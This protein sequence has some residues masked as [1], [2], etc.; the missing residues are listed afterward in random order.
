MFWFRT[1]LYMLAELTKIDNMIGLVNGR[2]I[3][4]ERDNLNH[5]N[6]KF[7][8]IENNEFVRNQ[9][10]YNSTTDKTD[11][12]VGLRDENNLNDIK[13]YLEEIKNGENG[14]N[15]ERGWSV[16]KKIETDRS[17]KD[18]KKEKKLFEESN[19]N[20]NLIIDQNHNYKQENKLLIQSILNN[21][22]NASRVEKQNNKVSIYNSK[23]GKL[24]SDQKDIIRNTY[25]D[26]PEK[27]G[28][29]ILHKIYAEIKNE[30]DG[31]LDVKKLINNFTTNNRDQK[32]KVVIKEKSE[33]NILAKKESDKEKE[34]KVNVNEL[35]SN[36]NEHNIKSNQDRTNI[37]KQEYKETKKLTENFTKVSKV[38]Q[39]NIND[40]KNNNSKIIS[41]LKDIYNKSANNE[42]SN[43]NES[44]LNKLNVTKTKESNEKVKAINVANSH[45]SKIS[46]IINN[47]HSDVTNK[48]TKVE[49][50]HENINISERNIKSD[51]TTDINK[52]ILESIHSSISRQSIDKQITV[53]LNPPELGKVVIKFQEQDSQITGHL[54]VSKPETRLEVEQALPQIIRNLNN[55]GIQI[56]KLDVVSTDISQ[57]QQE[58]QES[59]KEQLFSDD[60]TGQGHSSNN[61]MGRRGSDKAGFYDWL[62]N[63]SDKDISGLG[64]IYVGN[65]SINILI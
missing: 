56:R 16:D 51:I 43:L 32:S 57:S 30:P 54:E 55:S 21:K 14:K 7:S 25:T 58:S 47:N 27:K 6:N 19:L 52:Q 34:I 18:N 63:K 12:A 36:K 62:S 20:R 40:I 35:K 29:T 28:L 33:N 59:F 31:N 65:D 8:M 64:N 41:D 2:G 61:D 26:K 38:I 48:A 49:A 17:V 50:N 60:G 10:K 46:H 4:L 24:K 9:S 44:I 22:T 23:D 3:S 15:R 45:T 39:N 13:G 53:Q 11:N 37:I 1:I 42:K 5:K